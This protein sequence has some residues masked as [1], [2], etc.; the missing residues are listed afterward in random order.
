MVHA[1]NDRQSGVLEAAFSPDEIIRCARS[2]NPA[3]SLA[4]CFSAKE[5]T[6][7]ALSCCEGEGAFWHDI[8]IMATGEHGKVV[9]QGRLAKLAADSGVRGVVVALAN[10]RRYATA[11]ALALG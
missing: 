6:L 3:A 2:G 11:T 4:A 10:C 1:L 8:E 7:K 5:A 9:L